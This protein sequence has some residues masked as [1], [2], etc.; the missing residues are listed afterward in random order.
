MLSGFRRFMSVLIAAVLTGMAAGSDKPPWGTAQ[1]QS[2][3]LR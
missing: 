1:V 2:I 3:S